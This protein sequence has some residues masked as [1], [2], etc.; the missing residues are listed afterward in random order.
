VRRHFNLSRNKSLQT[1]E[2]TAASITA[3]GDAASGFLKIVL[4]TITS[5]LP[6]NVVITY[7]DFDLGCRVRSRVEVIHVDYVSAEESVTIA[8]QHTE[9]FKVFG[10][11]YRVREFRLV[12][13]ADVQDYI[14]KYAMRKLERIVEAEWKNGRLYHPLCKPLIISEIRSPGT[15]SGDDPV[16]RTGKYISASAL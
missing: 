15:R 16:G 12:L 1:L 13:C 14:L 9:R 5:P 10:E 8:L 4:S 2:T 11:M 7:R 3:A 6:L